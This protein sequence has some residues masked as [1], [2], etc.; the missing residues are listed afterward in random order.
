MMNLR[1]GSAA[2]VLVDGKPSHLA[3]SSFMFAS[4]IPY[5]VACPIYPVVICTQHACLVFG[6]PSAKGALLRE[7]V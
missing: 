6:S 4:L 5:G 7:P 3:R 1:A 2:A